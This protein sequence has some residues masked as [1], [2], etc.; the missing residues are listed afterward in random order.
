MGRSVAHVKTHSEFSVHDTPRIVAFVT[1]GQSPRID[2][3]PEI[4]DSIK[5]PIKTIEYGL[6]DNL[7]HELIDFH[8]H[9]WYLVK[10][11]RFSLA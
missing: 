3:V 2:L 6:L 4:L 7:D 8:K 10:F 11:R 5:I 1:L 9:N